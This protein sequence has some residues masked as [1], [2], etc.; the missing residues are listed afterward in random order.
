MVAFTP[1]SMCMTFNVKYFD[2]SLHW[3]KGH[4]TSPLGAHQAAL[5]HSLYLIYCLFK[6]QDNLGGEGSWKARDSPVLWARN[7]E[8]YHQMIEKMP[9]LRLCHILDSLH[10]YIGLDIFSTSLKKKQL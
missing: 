3:L 9:L 5:R 1:P 8:I 4:L 6:N 10:S 2:G 7:R